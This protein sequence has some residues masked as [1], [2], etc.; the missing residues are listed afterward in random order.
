MSLRLRLNH[1]SGGG[2]AVTERLDAQRNRAIGLY[3]T[4][5]DAKKIIDQIRTSSAAS[6]FEIEHR[7]G[8]TYAG[9]PDNRKI[10]DPI[11]GTPLP[12]FEGYKLPRIGRRA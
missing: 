11:D 3:K 6:I 12:M 1:R 7:A 10:G 4:S 8:I 5:K 9:R 2:Y